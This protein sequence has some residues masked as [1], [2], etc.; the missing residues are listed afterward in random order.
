M[1][2]GTSSRTALIESIFLTLDTFERIG[3]I[4][5]VLSPRYMTMV[6]NQKAYVSNLFS[7]SVTSVN[8]ETSTVLGTIPTGMNPED[9]ALIGNTA[10]VAN[11]G[12]GTA[13]STL[14]VIDTSSDTV[15]ETK[16]NGM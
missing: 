14:T 8:I 1:E 16:T 11:F 7:A 10:F 9:I 6:G 3:Q 4:S 12:F 2:L 5:G 15:M 13:D